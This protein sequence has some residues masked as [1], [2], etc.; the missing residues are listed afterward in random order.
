VIL[1]VT[2]LRSDSESLGR[3]LRSKNQWFDQAQAR[4]LEYEELLKERN[5]KL[6]S[7]RQESVGVGVSILNI[8]IYLYIYIYIYLYLY[9]Y[10]YIY[11][12]SFIRMLVCM[13]VCVYLCERVC[14]CV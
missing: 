7:L 2:K 8:Y 9:I 1:Q 5:E 4:L 6:E 10:I 3:Q 12:R 13:Y 11:I 14:L